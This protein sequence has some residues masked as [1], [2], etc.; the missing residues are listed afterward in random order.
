MRTSFGDYRAKMEKEEKKFKLGKYF[1]LSD[2][3]NSDYF[4]T[5]IY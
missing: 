5:S 3:S 1:P 2:L 4:S